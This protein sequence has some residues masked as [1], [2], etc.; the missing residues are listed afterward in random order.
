MK[1]GVCLLSSIPMRKEASH[2]SEM[3]SQLLFG[4][5]YKI[6]EHDGTWIKIIA[7]D[8]NYEGWI[9][10]DQSYEPGNAEIEKLFSSPKFFTA[11]LIN[12]ILRI[13]DMQIL[14]LSIG[15]TIF[16]KEQFSIGDY[17]FQY[18]GTV[19]EQN[20][21]Q[22]LRKAVTAASECLGIPYLWGGKT[23]FGFDCSGF[24]QIIYRMAGLKLPRDASQ[25][26]LIGKEI[27]YA[28]MQ[29]GD[30]AFFGKEKITHVGIIENNKQII[31]CSGKVR[32]DQLQPE[33]ILRVSEKIIT[34]PLSCIKRIEF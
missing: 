29:P 27:P 26:C 4:D 25:Q 6:T 8:D 15:S 2:K 23:I 3:V 24:V 12:P 10:A 17:Q 32:I 22:L 21:K 19:F 11:S 13:N 31:H 30:L 9:D 14:Y 5:L 20:N 1:T 16:G 33:G 18:P 34:H 7:L 28:E